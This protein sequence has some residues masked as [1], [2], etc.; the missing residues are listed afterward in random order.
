MKN[1]CIDTKNSFSILAKYC[2]QISTADNFNNIAYLTKTL[3]RK[4]NVHGGAAY[5]HTQCFCFCFFVP[6]IL[7][8]ISW[9]ITHMII[10]NESHMTGAAAA[11]S[12]EQ[13]K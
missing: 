1:H 9:F 8:A 13:K 2:Y 6:S 3:N 7:S 10:S 12:K 11:G 5:Q 4:R